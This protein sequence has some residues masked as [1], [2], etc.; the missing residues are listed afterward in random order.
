MEAIRAGSLISEI[1]PLQTLSKSLSGSRVYQL[2]KNLFLSSS[3]ILSIGF[4]SG[5]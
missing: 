4:K 5:E 2:V 1:N 3:Q